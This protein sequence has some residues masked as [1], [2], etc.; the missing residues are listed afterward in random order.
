MFSKDKM[1]AFS[2]ARD[3]YISKHYYSWDYVIAKDVEPD[4]KNSE[5]M[6]H[7]IR[8]FKYFFDTI[9]DITVLQDQASKAFREKRP[10]LHIQNE[11]AKT[12]MRLESE[13]NNTFSKPGETMSSF[14]LYILLYSVQV[15]THRVSLLRVYHL[16]RRCIKEEVETPGISE[17]LNIHETE[18]N[19]RAINVWDEMFDAAYKLVNLY[20]DKLHQY[21]D[22]LC[23]APVTAFLGTHF[24]QYL[25]PYLFSDNK[26]K[27]KLTET[28]LTR[29]IPTL[30]KYKDVINWDFSDFCKTDIEHLFYDRSLAAQWCGESLPVLKN[31]SLL[32]SA[33]QIPKLKPFVERIMA[34]FMELMDPA[35]SGD[36]HGMVFV[37]PDQ[38]LH[39]QS[40]NNSNNNLHKQIMDTKDLYSSLDPNTA[41][42][43]TPSFPMN[44]TLF[45]L[46]PSVYGG[47]PAQAAQRML[48]IQSIINH[49]VFQNTQLPELDGNTTFEQLRIIVD[50]DRPPPVEMED[51][52]ALP[53]VGDSQDEAEKECD[54]LLT[55]DTVM[56]DNMALG[57]VF[58]LFG[59][60]SEK[61]NT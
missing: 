43:T 1:L 12:S 16:V 40:N 22:V 59:F 48:S 32:R 49:S 23:F 17:N 33:Y 42:P 51:T 54:R 45:G 61:Y 55:A 20:C 5:Q 26:Q 29:L 30:E 57:N 38:P 19:I 8:Y 34:P 2:F 36:Y 58:H 44:D 27:S 35:F 9:Q 11:V 53:P 39:A 24:G 13:L 6:L 50:N 47:T 31:T 56:E 3:C 10:F 60:D 14:V 4:Y 25:F 37:E 18:D 46:P 52:Y 21:A 7:H 15:L 28:A 41:S